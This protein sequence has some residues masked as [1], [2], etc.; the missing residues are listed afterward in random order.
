MLPLHEHPSRAVP[1]LLARERHEFR[2]R[3]W[4]VD[5]RQHGT[6]RRRRDHGAGRT[7][8]RR[9]DAGTVRVGAARRALHPGGAQP[10]AQCAP[11][12]CDD[13]CAGAGDGRRYAGPV[14]VAVPAGGGAREGLRPVVRGRLLGHHQPAGLGRLRG[15][16]AGCRPPAASDPD[17]CRPGTSPWC[18]SRSPSWRG[19][20]STD[21]CRPRRRSQL[22]D[23]AIRTR[24][25]DRNR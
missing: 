6:R 3:R 10:A 14:P 23:I 17:R 22:F 9:A 11:R 8:P 7:Q 2:R 5:R 13:P 1:G 15:R 19:P 12:L 21:G 16:A 18:S 20:T 24:N 4:P 25:T